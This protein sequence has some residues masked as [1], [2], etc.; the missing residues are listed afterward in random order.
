MLDHFVLLRHVRIAALPGT[1][2]D[3]G[4]PLS[5]KS[6]RLVGRRERELGGHYP[7]S[8]LVQNGSGTEQNSTFNYTMLKATDNDRRTSSPLS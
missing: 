4:E 5:R 2:E 1:N 7:L 3:R 6:S 8:N